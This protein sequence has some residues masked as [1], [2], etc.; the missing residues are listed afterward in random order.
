MGSLTCNLSTVVVDEVDHMLGLPGRN[1]HPREMEKWRRHIPLVHQI[2][3]GIYGTPDVPRGLVTKDWR[4]QLVLASA[5]MT[6]GH[7]S[8]IV[9]NTTWLRPPTDEGPSYIRLG[10]KS[11]KEPVPQIPDVVEHACLVVHRNGEVRNAI[12]PTEEEL[13]KE[14][15]G[16]LP[17]NWKHLSGSEQRALR[18]ARESK[19]AC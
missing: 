16:Q 13:E 15:E 19:R 1:T 7:R 8:Y 18:T 11:E 10:F 2:L 14:K 17:F 6:A 5:T 9:S 3:D 4:P 12:V